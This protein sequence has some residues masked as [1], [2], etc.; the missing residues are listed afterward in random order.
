MFFGSFFPP[1]KTQQPVIGADWL[2]GNNFQKT[3]IKSNANTE[4]RTVCLTSLDD[5]LSI[6]ETV[7]SNFID[8]ILEEPDWNQFLDLV[9][10]L[11]QLDAAHQFKPLQVLVH[12][13]TSI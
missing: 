5:N 3:D 1:T 12:T 13:F 11:M 8:Q 4:P 10:G 6:Q 7:S 2:L 9:Q